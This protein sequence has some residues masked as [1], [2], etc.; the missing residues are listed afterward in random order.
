MVEDIE[1]LAS[2]SF[3]D[4]EEEKTSSHRRQNEIQVNTVFLS[5]KKQIERPVRIIQP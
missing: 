1:E 4:R 5:N 3:L 2:L